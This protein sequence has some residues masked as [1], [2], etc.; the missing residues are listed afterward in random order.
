MHCLPVMLC[1]RERRCVIIGGGPVAARRADA[2]V[3]A[4]ADVHL[5]APEL[6][7]AI[8]GLPITVHRRTYEPGDLDGALLVIVAT[9]RKQINQRVADDARQRGVLVNRTDVPD[10]GDL[11]VPAHAHHG[12]VTLAVHTSGVSAAAASTIRRELSDRLDPDWPTLLEAVAPYRALIQQRFAD[13]EQRRDRLRRLTDKAAMR[14]LK[15]SG[16]D[17]VKAHCDALLEGTP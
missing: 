4:G 6:D 5:V 11:V 2:L 7:P 8:E 13:A 14:I 16:V 12:P 10:D 1:V 17:A 15:D 3:D 9:D